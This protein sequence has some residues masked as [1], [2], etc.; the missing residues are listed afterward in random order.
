M[1]EHIGYLVGVGG[2]YR[3]D[4]VDCAKD[5]SIKVHKKDID[6]FKQ[7]CRTCNKVLVDSKEPELFDGVR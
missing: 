2:R 5:K 6:P 1:S 7:S 4:C 3:V